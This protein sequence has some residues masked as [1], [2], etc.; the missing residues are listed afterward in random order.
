MPSGFL[1]LRLLDLPA[2]SCTTQSIP[3]KNV[4]HIIGPLFTLRRQA[5]PPASS[6]ASA[7]CSSAWLSIS[8]KQ[9]AMMS[10]SSCRCR[11]KR[12]LDL[13][14]FGRIPSP[15]AILF[16]ILRPQLV[17]DFSLSAF[18]HGSYSN[19]STPIASKVQSQHSDHFNCIQKPWPAGL[20]ERLEQSW[21][22]VLSP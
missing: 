7:S 11:R 3:G 20:R 15:F 13:L 12:S 17:S 16:L 18:R 2:A 10:E 19:C 6:A 9:Q 5:S 21:A 14:V 8:L 1:R 22:P 4:P